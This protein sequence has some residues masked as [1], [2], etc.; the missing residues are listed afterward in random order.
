MPLIMHNPERVELISTPLRVGRSYNRHL[1]LPPD[2][3][4]GPITC[5]YLTPVGVGRD[6]QSFLL[7]P[8]DCL[9]SGVDKPARFNPFRVLD[10]W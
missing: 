4:P 10:Y 3:H 1:F 9:A 5:R 7:F 2:W 8:K 6:N